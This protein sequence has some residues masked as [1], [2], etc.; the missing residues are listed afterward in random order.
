MVKSDDKSEHSPLARPPKG[1]EL[2]GS[3]RSVRSL[4]RATNFFSTLEYAAVPNA[5]T[6]LFAPMVEQ[7][8]EEW[9]VIYKAA[10]E[11]LDTMV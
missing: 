11:H 9:G 6:D 7:V 2:V 1:P 5:A 4:L 10:E 8:C 3:K